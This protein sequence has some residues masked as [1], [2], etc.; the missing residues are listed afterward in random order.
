METPIPAL[1]AKGRT[2]TDL[3]I[4]I[5]RSQPLGYSECKATANDIVEKYKDDELVEYICGILRVLS[6]IARDPNCYSRSTGNYYQSKQ[7]PAEVHIRITCEGGC[8]KYSTAPRD[9][10][11]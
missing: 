2:G 4:K 7:S 10:N 1:I 8:S 9:E 11:Q 3:A 6:N 5:L